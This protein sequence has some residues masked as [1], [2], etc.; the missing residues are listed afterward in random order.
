MSERSVIVS[1]LIAL[2][3]VGLYRLTSVMTAD[4]VEGPVPLMAFDQAAVDRIEAERAGESPIVIER[5]EVLGSPRWMVRW[6]QDGRTVSWPADEGAVRAGLRVLST[7]TIDEREATDA[8]DGGTVTLRL[9]D[10]STRSLRFAADPL[11]GRVDV[12]SV[13]EATRRGL[14]DAGLFDAFI[15]SGLLAWRDG[16]AMLPFGAGP[17]RVDLESPTGALA[18]ARRRGRWFMLE[19]VAAAVDPE[20]AGALTG[21]L[22]GLV[23][24]RIEPDADPAD[25]AYGLTQP[26]ATVITETDYRL[27]T[28][29]E[30]TGGT[31][32]QTMRIGSPVD[33]SGGQ[34]YALLEWTR[35]T[36]DAPP[37]VVA[38]PIIVRI[39]TALLN[40][41]ST[42]PEPLVSP[43]SMA[44]IPATVEHISLAAGDRQI[45]IERDGKAW[46]TRHDPLLPDES[47]T[48][49]AL[50]ALMTETKAEVVM[51]VK[52]EEVEVG[53]SVLVRLSTADGSPPTEVRVYVDGEHALVIDGSIA[54]QYAN[55]KAL[56]AELAALVERV[57]VAAEP[58]GG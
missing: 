1:V 41:L 7:A 48:I 16:R 46:R 17:A 32:R 45:A 26:L 13:G 34:V 37:T 57:G 33:A 19:P 50:L 24:D 8:L 27:S 4:T 38:G 25:A 11:A 28:G 29:A 42:R 43:I 55:R 35:P 53:D 47:A 18:I 23:V 2:A 22:A 44:A 21:M 40:R 12:E 14:T 6:T 31:L 49:E 56:A 3:M 10:G 58:A 30:T 52:A 39:E 20:A 51:A 9:A 54:R 36:N 5:V 15:R